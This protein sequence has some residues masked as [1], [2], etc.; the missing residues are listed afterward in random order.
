MKVKLIRRVGKYEEFDPCL[1]FNSLI[2]SLSFMKWH[3]MLSLYF[4]PIIHT[5]S[6]IKYIHINI[7]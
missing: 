7:R 6:E 2:K 5:A 3:V 4:I 1:L